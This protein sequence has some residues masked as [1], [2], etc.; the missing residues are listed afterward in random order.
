MDVGRL[1]R[2]KGTL[3][4]HQL[5]GRPGRGEVDAYRSVRA[6]VASAVDDALLPEFDRLFPTELASAGRP[7]GVQAQEAVMYMNRLAGWIGGLI[8]VAAR[9]GVDS[10]LA[11]LDEQIASAGSEAE[12]SRWTRLKEAAANMGQSVLA[13]ALGAWLARISG[14]AG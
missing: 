14:A 12:R 10:L 1:L 3:E 6:E 13:E 8:E 4:A 2:L 7:W 9:E 5:A 11:L